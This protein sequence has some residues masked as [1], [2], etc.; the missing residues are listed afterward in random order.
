LS[1]FKRGSYIDVFAVAEPPL[2]ALAGCGA[3]WAWERARFRWIVPVLGAFLIAQSISLLI[4]PRDPGIARRLFSG[5]GLQFALSPAA[6]DNAVAAARRCPPGL[7]YSGAPFIAFLADRRMPGDQPDVFIVGSA[8]LNAP[9][10]RR[11]DADTPRC[12][13]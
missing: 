13:S 6:V 10:A 5:Y 9:F 11:A 12:P 8:P 7:A 2:L 3:T 4:D 1:L